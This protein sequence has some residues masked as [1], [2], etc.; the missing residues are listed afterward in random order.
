VR[1]A[2]G[3][4]LVWAKFLFYQEPHKFFDMI[5]H[6]Y[7]IN[8]QAGCHHLILNDEVELANEDEVCNW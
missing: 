4:E 8:Y 2:G 3:Y 7:Q 1:E 6:S 5:I